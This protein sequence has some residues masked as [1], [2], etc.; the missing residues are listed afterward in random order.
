[1]DDRLNVVVAVIES[2]REDHL[3]CD[4]YARE[5]TPFLDQVAR[6][7][8]RFSQMFATAPWT[9]PS[10]ASLATGMFAA[11]HG[12]TAENRFLSGRYTT[13]A[14]HL[15]A[16]GYRTA[17]FCTNP[18]I[19][20]ETG[21]GRGFDAFFTQRY[22]NRVAARAI[23]FGRRASDTLLR[24][25][26]AGARRSNHALRRW[27]AGDTRPFFAFVHYNETHLPLHPPPPYDRMFLPPGVTPARVR[28]VN[29][30]RDKYLARQMEMDE[31]DF[32]ILR[33]LYDGALRYT[34]MRLREIA[35]YLQSA[36]QWERTLF[37]VTGSHGIHLGDHH[38]LG[39]KLTL[40]DALLRVP[41]LLRCPQRVPQGYVIDE[42]AQTTD[43][44]PTVLR[45]LELSAESETHGRPLIEQGHA[46]PGP[47]FIVA[48]RF[49]P[50][51]AR[52][53]QRFASTDMRPYE[54]RQKAIRTRREKFIWQSDE[55]NEL[56]DLIADPGEER[57]L[58][59]VRTAAADALRRRLFDW[60]ASVEKFEAPDESAAEHNSG[61]HPVRRA[62]GDGD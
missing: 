18:W 32:T 13:L 50:H 47:E 62:L 10:Q 51:L 54:V 2:A 15:K 45:V 37:V 59:E 24:R 33:A 29:Q 19:S 21:F 44:M 48:E 25:G 8:V 35:E 7:G 55:A 38:L 52:F 34:D 11:T 1:M 60:L 30:D 36:G 46:T 27:I 17:A 39:D 58:I 61:T 49:R 40:Y 20:P 9:L 56:Y 3:S 4:G 22:H 42:L 14:E 53:R 5:T 16:A 26:D 23:A 31:E 28:E 12:A 41:L 43:I 6:Q 57:N